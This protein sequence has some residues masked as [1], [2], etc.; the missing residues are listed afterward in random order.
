MQ[1]PSWIFVLFAVTMALVLGAAA[2]SYLRTK[3]DQ[4]EGTKSKLSDD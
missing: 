2:F 4:E 1:E 3:N